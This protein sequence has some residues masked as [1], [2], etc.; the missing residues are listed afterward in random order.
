MSK[1]QD[2]EWR[3]VDVLGHPEIDLS[4]YCIEHIKDRDLFPFYGR[5]RVRVVFCLGVPLLHKYYMG[6]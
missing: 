2:S 3:L 6:G 5:D 1:L 4:Q